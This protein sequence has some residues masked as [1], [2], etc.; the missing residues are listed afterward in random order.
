MMNRQTFVFKT[1]STSLRADNS[2]SSIAMAYMISIVFV[3]ELNSDSTDDKL[4]V[5]ITVNRFP[6][7][8]LLFGSFRIDGEIRDTAS[9]DGITDDVPV[10]Q[11][12]IQAA[13][14]PHPSS[15]LILGSE[16]HDQQFA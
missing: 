7:N 3:V 16:Y 2:M 9:I 5:I 13:H 6:I 8:G 1:S 4:A 14:L 15:W 10:G 11:I 12:V